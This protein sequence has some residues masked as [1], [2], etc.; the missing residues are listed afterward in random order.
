M[1][2]GGF[3]EANISTAVQGALVQPPSPTALGCHKR[4]YTY[5][6]TQADENG[7]SIDYSND[8]SINEN[9]VLKII[10]FELQNGFRSRV[11]G[12]C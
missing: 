5:R 4:L 2:W 8:L 1:T 3:G 10:K 9:R 11:L 12:S 6:I 7:K